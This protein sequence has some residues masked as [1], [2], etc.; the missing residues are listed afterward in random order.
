MPRHVRLDH[1]RVTYR[2][3]LLADDGTVFMPYPK[4][5]VR[6]V[7]AISPKHAMDVVRKEDAIQGARYAV[8]YTFERV[9]KINR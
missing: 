6:E 4:L 5:Q 2:K 3:A 1:Y 9:E 7:R 8:R